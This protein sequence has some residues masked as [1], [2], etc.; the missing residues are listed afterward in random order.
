MRTSFLFA[1][2]VLIPLLSGSV[3]AQN[4]VD[5]EAIRQADAIMAKVGTANSSEL[6]PLVA[7]IQPLVNTAG[8][9]GPCRTFLISMQSVAS[10]T[11]PSDTLNAMPE[12]M[13]SGVKAQNEANAQKLAADRKTC[14]DAGSGQATEPV[15]NSQGAAVGNAVSGSDEQ[16]A[17]DESIPIH[18]RIVNLRS[19]LD[20]YFQAGDQASLERLNPI[21]D[22]IAKNNAYEINCR[23][24][25]SNSIKQVEKSLKSIR[26]T[27]EDGKN[28]GKKL[29]HL[30]STT[31]EGLLE[32]CQ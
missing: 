20:G 23:L 24:A 9:S 5:A 11:T 15:A 26:A 21:F 1:L 16:M 8:L 10:A 30:A 31:A 6:P 14:V 12:E 13:K 17:G 27:D 22:K 3:M 29:A 7:Q 18:D 25:A 32:N 4:L 2:F 28:F 19:K